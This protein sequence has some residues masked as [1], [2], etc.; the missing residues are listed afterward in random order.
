MND[1]TKKTPIDEL[2]DG[3][4]PELAAEIIRKKLDNLYGKEPS[5]KE[6]IKEVEGLPSGKMSKHQHYMDQLSKSGLSLH[7]IQTKWHQYYSDL[8]D[9]QKRQVW[10]E[11]YRH[12][13]QQKNKPK[14]EVERHQTPTESDHPKEP[15]HPAHQ[16]TRIY[17]NNSQVSVKKDLLNRV[18]SRAKPITNNHHVRSLIFG[19]S[20]GGLVILILLFSFFNERFITPLIRP[21]TNVS[22]SPIIVNPN[23]AGTAAGPEPKIIIPKINVE[24]PVVYDEPSIEEKAV[25]KALERGVVHYATTVNPGE[26]GNAVIFGHS[27]GNILN[28]GKYKFAFILLKSLEKDDTFIVDKDG[29]RYVYK[30]YQ[31]YITPPTDI[32][33][34]GARDRPSTMT[35][36]TC[37][38]PGMST[39]RLIIVGEQIFPDPATNKESSISSQTG[40]PKVLPSNSPSLWQRIKDWF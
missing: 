7:E 32:G 12:H 25:Q 23:G 15:T 30:V 3:N 17:G 4:N 40:E 39:N 11:F 8:P 29:K 22:A 26:K 5:A 34:L 2:G 33:I 1:P 36:V 13:E 21:S 31:K 27:S 28:S 35:L 38:P 37:D 14:P 18:Q 6:E 19:F 9:D 20:M 10:N 16:P 24:A